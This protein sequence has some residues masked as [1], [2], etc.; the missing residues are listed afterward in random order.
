[1][2]KFEIISVEGTKSYTLFSKNSVN[3]VLEAIQRTSKYI[4]SNEGRDVSTE[5]YLDSPNNLLSSAGII[6]TK[7]I[8]EGKACF[9][10]EREEYLPEKKL[11]L[12]KE[13]KVFIHPIGLKDIAYDHSLFLIDGITSMFSTKFHIDLENILKTISPKI[14]IVSK[15]TYFKILNRIGFKARITYEIISIKNYQTKRKSALLM[16]NLQHL[17]SKIL[18]EEFDVFTSMLEKYCKEIIPTNETKYE[19]A[20][21]M[22]G[23]S[24]K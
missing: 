23:M 20:K 21:R 9:R 7:V 17:S 4:L 24:K 8:E 12:P 16:L 6:L 5:I 22:T 2:G 15:K 1:M 10:V 3:K 18:L 19:I 14:E 11:I 13:K